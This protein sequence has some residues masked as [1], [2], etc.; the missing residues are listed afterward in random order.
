MPGPPLPPSSTLKNVLVIGDSVSIGYTTYANLPDKLKDVALV[1]HGPWDVSD[2]GAGNTGNGVACLDNWLATQAQAPV[3]WD[4]VMFNFGLHNLGNSTA[5]ETSYK[6]QLTNITARLGKTGATLLYALTTP[7]MPDATEGNMVVE[8]LNA[9]ALELMQAAAIP[10]LDLYS[11]VVQHCGKVYTDC[12]WCR[13][14]PCSYHY[15][16]PGMEAQSEAVAAAIRT[17]L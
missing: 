17:M 13:M 15:N 1:Q 6:E 2:G 9:I 8:Q 5:A 16:S 7:F 3:K 10:I 4:L 14:S 11:L 12:D